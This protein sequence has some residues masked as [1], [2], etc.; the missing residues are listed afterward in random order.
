MKK[1]LCL[2]GKSI[3]IA[4][5]NLVYLFA[6]VGCIGL[7]QYTTDR[8]TIYFI[9]SLAYFYGLLGIYKSYK[10]VFGQ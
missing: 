4:L 3:F 6:C 2:T 10:G 1:L 7:I 9:I 5:H 8:Q